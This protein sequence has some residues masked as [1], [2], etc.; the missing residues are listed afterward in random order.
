[1]EEKV[2]NAIIEELKRQ[3]AETPDLSID[4]EDDQLIVEGPIDLDALVMVV[5]G[6]LAGGP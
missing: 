6:S 2:R 5:I 4:A 3:A 1:M